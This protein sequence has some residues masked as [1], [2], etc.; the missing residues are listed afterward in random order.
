MRSKQLSTAEAAR[1]L[2]I[3][4]DGVT[5]ALR[6]GLLT[7]T[8]TPSAWQIDRASVTK[9]AAADR[10]PGPKRKKVKR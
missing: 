8:R 5:Q 3:S 1:V 10:R 7:G 2:G 6:R 4:R 9:Y